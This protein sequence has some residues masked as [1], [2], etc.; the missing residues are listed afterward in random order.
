MKPGEI[1]ITAH[2]WQQLES[3]LLSRTDVETK[4]FVF[5]QSVQLDSRTQFLV[6]EVVEVPADAYESRSA[7]QVVIREEYVARMLQHSYRHGLSLV[8]VHTH[9]WSERP[10]FSSIDDRTD[11]KR[12]SYTAEKMAAHGFRDFRH[13]SVVFGLEMSFDGRYWEPASCEIQR[14]ERLRV[15]GLPL[16]QKCA[17]NADP[18][19][20]PS[21][22]KAIYDRQI[23]AFGDAG[24]SLLQGMAVAIVGLGGMGSQI[25]QALALLG[26]GKLIL[27][28]PDEV[29][30]SNANR[31]VGVFA[32]HFAHR[33]SKVAAISETLSRLPRPPEITIRAAPVSDPGVFPLLAEADVIVGAVDSPGARMY[34]N[35]VAAALLV[36]YLDAGVGIKADS[37]RATD[38]GG[39]V[40]VIVPGATPCLACIGQLA[41]QVVQEEL[42]PEQRELWRSRGY[43]EG[44]DVKAPQV[45]FL[46]GVVANLL[47]NEFVKLATGVATTVPYLYYDLLARH[48]P[49]VAHAVALPPRRA[50]CIVCSFDGLLARGP[51]ALD[52]TADACE[53]AS[54]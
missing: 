9:P 46:N 54:T 43:I 5:A 3:A 53:M 1:K 16:T 22:S 31:L 33:S 28:D 12:Y 19:G 51:G 21:S 11:Q 6:R 35:Q 42:F 2:Q 25:A 7:A 26:V 20:L 27:I 44:E 29:E 24:Q 36:P 39:Q 32:E 47:I 23:R 48:Q 50:D 37:G 38:G 30:L 45:V 10:T 17:T 40:Q 15:I 41:A 49:I 13:A 8:D 14:I 52:V 34:V 4:A 18:S